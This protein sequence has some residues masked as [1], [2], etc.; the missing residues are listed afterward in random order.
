M[1]GWD[2]AGI[3][4]A[5]NLGKRLA[6]T[7]FR[8]DVVEDLRGECDWAAGW[9]GLWSLASGSAPLGDQSLE[10]VDGDERGAP[11]RLDRVDVRKEA[12]DGGAADTERLGGL[13]A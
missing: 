2:A 10:F 8:S 7:A 13:S 3:E 12:G 6:G 5:G 11:G 9:A 4:I 1:G